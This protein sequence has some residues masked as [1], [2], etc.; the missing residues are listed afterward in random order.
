M[1]C[2][3][4]FLW[5]LK[6]EQFRFIRRAETWLSEQILTWSLPTTWS[7]TWRPPCPVITV[8]RSV[9]CVATSTGTTKMTSRCPTINSPAT[10]TNLAHLGRSPFLM[11]CVKTVVKGTTVRT[12]TQLAKMCFPSPLTVAL[13]QRPKVLSL[14]VTISSARSR[15]L[16]TA[17]LIC[18]L[19]TETEMCF[20]MV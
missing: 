3:T 4:T 7:I 8:E 14:A 18:A 2:S 10:S 6:R 9:A 19:P 16:T 12:V 13:W 20:V 17:C 11:W 15:T 1:E 5:I